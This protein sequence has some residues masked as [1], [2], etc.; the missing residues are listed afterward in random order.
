LKDTWYSTWLV[1]SDFFKQVLGFP[2]FY[3]ATIIISTFGGIVDFAT[4]KNK[5]GYKAFFVNILGSAF[6]GIITAM[7]LDNFDKIPDKVVYAMCGIAGYSYTLALA[8]LTNLYKKFM[9][10]I[11][12]RLGLPNENSNNKKPE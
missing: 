1:I 11:N 3:V 2:P 5:K 4:N 10:S 12:D 9:K 8:V 6:T 7:I